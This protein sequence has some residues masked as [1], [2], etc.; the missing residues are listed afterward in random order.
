MRKKN[1]EKGKGE[2]EMIDVSRAYSGERFH[3]NYR[4]ITEEEQNTHKSKT[5]LTNDASTGTDTWRSLTGVLT[6]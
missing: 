2:R 4:K 6:F 5:A 1:R 3:A